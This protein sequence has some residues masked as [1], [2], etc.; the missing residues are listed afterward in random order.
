MRLVRAV[1][2]MNPNATTTNPYQR[3]VIVAALRGALDLTVVQTTHRDHA[4]EVAQQATQDGTDIVIAHGGDGTVN[5]AVNGMLH[6]GPGPDVPML[7]II[8][9][10]SANVMARNLGLPRTPIL[11]TQALLAAVNDPDGPRIRRIGLGRADERWFTFNAGL[12]LD[13]EAVKRVEQA[14]ARGKRATPGLYLRSA[15]RAYF[16]QD[17]ASGPI[18]VRVDGQDPVEGLQ[19]L[20]VTNSSPWTYMGP[21]AVVATP[22][23]SFDAGLDLLGSSRLEL[24]RV[25]GHGSQILLTR[26]GARGR[27][28][29]AEHDT[30]RVEVHC[31]TAL[32]LQ[33]DGDYLG[34]TSGITFRAVPRALSVLVN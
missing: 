10:G 13:A 15:V 6:S 4:T 23:A 33:I 30:Q 21:V 8:P 9:G 11:A 1:V 17:H 22:R 31:E 26:Q 28:V 20:V 16:G 29:L 14:R 7:G 27:H 32:P 18:T 3:D 19:L 2:I 25:L 24:R 34:E 12:G 5:E